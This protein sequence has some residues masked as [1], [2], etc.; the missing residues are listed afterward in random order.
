MQLIY[1]GSD[2][3]VYGREKEEGGREGKRV[4]FSQLPLWAAGTQAWETIEF[5]VETPQNHSPARRQGSWSVYTSPLLSWLEGTFKL[6]GRLNNLHPLGQSA[7]VLQN[8]G[9]TR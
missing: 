7:G 4:S 6:P 1:L 8:V 5:T 3:R 2:A 9:E